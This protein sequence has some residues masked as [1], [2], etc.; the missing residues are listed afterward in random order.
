MMTF[1]KKNWS[2]TDGYFMTYTYLSAYCGKNRSKISK[3]SIKNSGIYELCTVGCKL[4]IDVGIHFEMTFMDDYTVVLT[5]MSNDKIV[6]LKSGHYPILE[7]GNYRPF[8]R[9]S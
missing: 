7:Y 5:I 2:E 9:M 3:Q 8:F 1:F 6:N 4:A